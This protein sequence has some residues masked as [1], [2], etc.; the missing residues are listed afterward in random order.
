M[1]DGFRHCPENGLNQGEETVCNNVRIEKFVSHFIPDANRFGNTHFVP[2]CQPGFAKAGNCESLS[3]ETEYGVIRTILV[4]KDTKYDC[5]TTN[6]EVH[7]LLKCNGRCLEKTNKNT[8]NISCVHF[9]RSGK[10]SLTSE[11]KSVLTFF[12]EGTSYQT[13]KVYIS[14][15]KRYS[16][17]STLTTYFNAT[18][19]CRGTGNC[20]PLSSVCDSHNDCGDWEDEEHCFNRFKCSQ[21]S[22]ETV[23]VSKICDG[24]FD[25]VNKA[26]ECGD[27]CKHASPENFRILDNTVYR[28]FAVFI[29]GFGMIFNTTAIAMFIINIKSHKGISTLV[30]DTMV[31]MIAVGDLM[32]G[33]YLVTIFF[34][35]YH[36]ES[37]NYCEERYKWFG[38]RECDSIGII[39]TF[40]TMLSL[41]CM[42]T[43]SLF[44]VISIKT[45]MSL[46]DFDIKNKLKLVAI[47]LI[48][49]GVS[50]LISVL[51]VLK[52]L[53]DYFVNGLYYP[54]NPLFR[55]DIM[56]KEQFKAALE[57]W[58]SLKPEITTDMSWE[59][60]RLLVK[61]LF[62]DQ[63]YNDDISV[64]FYGNHGV[65]LFKY[66]VTTED[67]QWQY[68]IAVLALNTLCFI[69][70]TVSYAMIVRHTISSSTSAG[71]GDQM[72]GMMTKLQ[73]KVTIIIATDFATWIPFTTVAFLHF[74][75]FVDASRY[76]SLSS[77]VLLPINGVMNPLIY[78]GDKIFHLC[79][80][81]SWYCFAV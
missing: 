42:A 19:R 26:D 66:F 27:Q 33:G 50:A 41:L 2:P 80:R 31:F 6:R 75:G 5:S 55:F 68:S 71:T 53:E 8:G 78:N 14:D 22:S 81:V 3:F 65:C 30:N 56:K 69:I 52:S 70:I 4:E 15:Q 73:R 57:S 35:D 21:N 10:C 47:V 29:G 40:G 51:P 54:E 46:A 77:I 39:S 37:N 7:T 28:I 38:S 74:G 67:P 43:L 1:C 64:G 23:H 25:C 12:S 60:I 61:Q 63:K 59:D 76:Y 58:N 17:N 9:Y 62:P 11:P 34:A 16:D 72:K 79:A 44:R 18:F 20:I 48:Q 36:F 32:V 24:S 45:M 49:I 13:E